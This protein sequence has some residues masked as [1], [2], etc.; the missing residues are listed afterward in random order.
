[1]SATIISFPEI[2]RYATQTPIHRRAARRAFRVACNA[3]AVDFVAAAFGAA[4]RAPGTEGLGIDDAVPLFVAAMR[5]EL[6]RVYPR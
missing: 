3:I 1:M 4:G 2:V 5:R 6:R